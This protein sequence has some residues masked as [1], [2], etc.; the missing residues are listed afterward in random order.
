MNFTEFKESLSAMKEIIYYDRDEYLREKASNNSKLKQYILNAENLLKEC[1]D[2]DERYFL[3]GTL[4]NLYRIYGEPQKAIAILEE[5]ITLAKENEK[6]EIILLIRLGEAF[7]YNH[8]H[9]KALEIFNQ[10]LALCKDS[11]IPY[12]DFALQHK[13]KCLMEM[14]QLTEAENCLKEAL[15][16]RKQKGDKSLSE[17]TQL[18]LDVLGKL[19]YER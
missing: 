10:A 6:R 3:M 18:A 5:C 17:S 13:G 16:L 14:D 15:E 11:N 7:K 2:S 1:N 4:G 8:N 9:Q 12:L 19:K